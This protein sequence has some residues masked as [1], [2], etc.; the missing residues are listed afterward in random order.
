MEKSQKDQVAEVLKK[1]PGSDLDALKNYI[2]GVA[3]EAIENTLPSKI[4]WFMLQLGFDKD[5]AQSLSRL[6]DEAGMSRTVTLRKALGLFKI[7]LDAEAEGN[8][9]AILS[10]RDD[11]VQDIVGINPAYE[12]TAQPISK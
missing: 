8:R 2:I 9:L 4:D 10:P 1:L 11:I 7:A 5:M 6:A 12:A 3:S